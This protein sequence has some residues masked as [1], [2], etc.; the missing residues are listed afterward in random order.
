MFGQ[1]GAINAFNHTLII[2]YDHFCP[3]GATRLPRILYFLRDLAVAWTGMEFLFFLLPP[4]RLRLINYLGRWSTGSSTTRSGAR[5]C[6]SKKEE[7][8][9][10]STPAK[11]F[12]EEKLPGAQKIY[13]WFVK[14]FPW[15]RLNLHSYLLFI[16]VRSLIVGNVKGFC[17]SLRE[18]IPREKCS[19]F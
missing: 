2:N 7:K 13:G 14:R 1:D 10:S 12:E 19:F 16:S 17:P 9:C 4:L 6:G 5:S 15:P 3:P 11:K 18:A 8:T